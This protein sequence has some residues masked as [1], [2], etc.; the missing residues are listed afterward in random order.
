MMPR[1][2]SFGRERRRVM[3][4]EDRKIIA[5]HEAGHAIISGENH[6]GLLYSQSYYLPEDKSGSTVFTPKKDILN[7]SKRRVLNQICC[8]M[9]AGIPEIE[10]GD[11]T[12][13]VW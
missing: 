10:I 11:I 8:A 2:I 12:S 1:K 13:G 6:D 7:H 3:D 5:Y 4:D 9:R